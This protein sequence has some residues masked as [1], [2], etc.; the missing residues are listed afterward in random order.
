MVVGVMNDPRSKTGLSNESAGD[1]TVHCLGKYRS[2][3][4]YNG[5]VKWGN[6][7]ASRTTPGE[8]G[9]EDRVARV[10]HYQFGTMGDCLMCPDGHSACA[11]SLKT[12]DKLKGVRTI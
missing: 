1:G 2:G 10:V 9:R 5:Q 11:E 4:S 8:L 12:H 3:D 7:L 6:A